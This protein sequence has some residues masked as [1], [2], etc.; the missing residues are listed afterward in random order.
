MPVVDNGL[1]ILRDRT[2]GSGTKSG[3]VV[4]SIGFGTN[5]A[6]DGAGPSYPIDQLG[7]GD[8]SNNAAGQANNNSYWKTSTD[9]TQTSG[10]DGTD[11]P[12]W[13]FEATWLTTEISTSPGTT[14]VLYEIGTSSGALDGTNPV[15]NDGTRLFSR[16]RIGG[17]AG[18]GKTQDI[19]LVGR[20]KVTY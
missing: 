6:A 2:I 7:G 4:D 10:G 13:Q 11:D 15:G 12:F 9:V 20:V 5:D 16:K 3:F 8:G 14:I 19:D 17:S 1:N 18:I